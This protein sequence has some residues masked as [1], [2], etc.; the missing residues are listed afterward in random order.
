MSCFR[1]HTGTLA[2][3]SLILSIIQIIRVLL[4]YLDHKLK[5]SLQ[6]F[7]TIQSLQSPESN[8]NHQPVLFSSTGA[9]NKFTKFLLCC[10][11]CCFY[12]LEKCIKF[13]NRN[14]YIMV[15]TASVIKSLKLMIC[16]VGVSGC[17]DCV[18]PL[19][20]DLRQKLLHLSQRCLLPPHEEHDQVSGRG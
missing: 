6:F 17:N 7:T 3:G 8:N 20:G 2:F 10:L 13:I 16:G 12:C 1:Y 14:A 11:K 18:W 9:K 4:E 19:D 5:G 15:C